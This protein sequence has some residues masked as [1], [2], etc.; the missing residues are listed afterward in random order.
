[1]NHYGLLLLLLAT[2][3]PALAGPR[4]AEGRVVDAASGMPIPDATVTIGERVLRS[5]AEGRFA[6]PSS[7]ERILV[8]A[9]GYRAANSTA[10]EVEAA[11]GTVR[12]TAFMPRALYLSVYGIGARSLR[13]GALALIRRGF[14]N[15][16]VVDVKG[17]RGIVPYPSAVPLVP[18]AGARQ[19]TTIPKLAALVERLHQEGVYAIAR[20]VVFKDNPLATAREDL[21]VHRRNGEVFRDGE[22]LAWTDPFLSEVREYN[23]AIATEAAAAGFDEI[24]FDYVRFPD[25]AAQLRFAHEPDGAA[26]RRAIEDF[27]REARERLAR[28][29]VFVSV[30]IFGYVCWNT[31]DT[32]I[33]QQLET[34]AQLADY[35]C[36]MLY[37]SS[38]Q[39]GIPGYRDPVSHPYEVVWLTLENGRR[40]VNLPSNRFRPWI[41]GF[42]DYAFHRGAFGT[43]QVEA[44]I[45]AAQEFGSDGWM[46]WN[47]QNRYEHA[48]P[49]IPREVSPGLISNRK[50]AEPGPPEA[51]AGAASGG[52][53][54]SAEPFRR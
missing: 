40:R 39:F 23:I 32:G 53:R 52:M 42:R 25:V 33:G 15:A 16:L 44:Q 1:M 50:A 17:D 18:I 27:L 49:S 7:T 46:L 29:N 4:L 31:N 24:Q 2:S 14:A 48:F 22:G 26:R 30:D 11:G 47:P 45:R 6:R 12:L 43:E 41:Q 38:F 9:A 5:D 34:I 35:L 8:R 51:L 54:S 20:I 10:A 28:F 19:I 3:V 13:E 37:P 36:P 21:A